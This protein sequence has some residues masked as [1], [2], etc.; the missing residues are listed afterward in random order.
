MTGSWV[1]QELQEPRPRECKEQA[2]L[3]QHPPASTAA[4]PHSWFGLSICIS[5]LREWSQPCFSWAE[6]TPVMAIALPWI[7]S[8]L[9]E[10]S[11]SAELS[12]AAAGRAV[13]G[14]GP[15]RSSSASWSKDPAPCSAETAPEAGE[16]AWREGGQ[17]TGTNFSLTFITSE[18]ARS[19][20]WDWSELRAPSGR[21]KSVL[22]G[23]QPGP[24]PGR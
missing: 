4:S 21:A 19:P 16:Q 7:W 6:S 24:L 8:Q 14:T 22:C 3:S 1:H 11:I 17:Q 18:K 15:G 9:W 5:L 23:T 12:S 10:V 20:S 13:L 2:G